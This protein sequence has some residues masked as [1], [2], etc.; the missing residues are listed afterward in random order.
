MALT[1]PMT[2]LTPGMELSP[3]VAT[4]IFAPPICVIVAV[5]VAEAVAVA[6]AGVVMVVVV[7]INVKV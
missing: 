2:Y 5:G 6:V 1:V 3:M 7:K 4:Q